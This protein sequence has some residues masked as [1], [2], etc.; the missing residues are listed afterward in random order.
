[1]AM[2]VATAVVRLL[3]IDVAVDVMTDCM[4]LM[5]WVRRDCTSPLRVRVKKATDWR[6]RWRKT[7]VRSPCMTRWPTEVVSHLR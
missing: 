5:S 6:C 3:A 1:M 7:S 4:P 2:A